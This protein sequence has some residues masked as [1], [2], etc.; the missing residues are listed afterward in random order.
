M[1]DLIF[2][3]FD[4]LHVTF[5]SSGI[6]RPDT[7]HLPLDTDSLLPFASSTKNYEYFYRKFAQPTSAPKKT[8]ATIITNNAQTYS[9]NVPIK[10]KSS[11]THYI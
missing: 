3:D 1:L 6:I 8:R 5:V 4:D 11:K 2:S 7:Y 9:T 10:D